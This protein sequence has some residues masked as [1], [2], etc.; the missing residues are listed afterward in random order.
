MFPAYF[1]LGLT[2]VDPP[3]CRV[4]AKSG[5]TV[6]KFG[7]PPA[8]GKKLKFSFALYRSKYN[9]DR[10]VAGGVDLKNYSMLERTK[11]LLILI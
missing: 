11:V 2:S 7:L 3:T 1:D 4:V 6:I 9:E 10:N 8:N 5:Q